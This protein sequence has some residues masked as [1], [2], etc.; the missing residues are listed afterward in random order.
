MVT[1]KLKIALDK[2][3][4]ESREGLSASTVSV[5]TY[6]LRLA[7]CQVLTS[8]EG[9]VKRQAL[10]SSVA[11]RMFCIPL[12]YKCNVD[13]SLELSHLIHLHGDQTSQNQFDSRCEVDLSFYHIYQTAQ[14]QFSIR[15]CEI[16]ESGQVT[17]SLDLGT[18]LPH[19]THIYFYII[20]K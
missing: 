18:M 19:I 5:P 2:C 9:L 15:R 8:P 6:K 4:R 16:Q 20:C 17:N 12:T 10:S 11:N 13:L 7:Q 1:E 14:N 3:H